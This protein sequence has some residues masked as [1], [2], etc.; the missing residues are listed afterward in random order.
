M[1][2]FSANLGFLWS[3]LPLL[4]RIERAAASQFT[5]VELHWPMTLRPPKYVMLVNAMA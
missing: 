1:L 4:E 5:A 2:R 3:Q